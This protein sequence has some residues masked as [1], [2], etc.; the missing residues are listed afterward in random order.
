[1]VLNVLHWDLSSVTAYS[2]LDNILR[3]SSQDDKLHSSEISRVRI[4]AE[5]FVALAATEP[6]FMGYSP[7]VVAGASLGA[8]ICGLNADCYGKSKVD[9]SNQINSLLEH[10]QSATNTDKVRIN[11]IAK[12]RLGCIEN[13]IKR[14][15]LSFIM[16]YINYYKQL[17]CVAYY[18]PKHKKGHRQLSNSSLFILSCI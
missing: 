18:N 12:V 9:H 6:S 3:R 16:D 1:M 17:N 8:A 15:K 2:I 10:L 4:H 13:L 7:A 5:T 14:M 11:T